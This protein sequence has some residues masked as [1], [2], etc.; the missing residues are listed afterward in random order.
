MSTPLS[1]ISFL[2][3]IECYRMNSWNAVLRS[4]YVCGRGVRGCVTLKIVMM[5]KVDGSTSG[6]PM[7]IRICS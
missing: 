5:L 2:F 1:P 3:G 4:L 6:N 7:K